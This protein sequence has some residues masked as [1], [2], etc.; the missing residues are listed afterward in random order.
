VPPRSTRLGGNAAWERLLACVAVMFVIA[1]DGHP[2]SAEHVPAAPRFWGAD[3]LARSAKRAPFPAHVSR[4]STSRS[5]RR[6]LLALRGGRPDALTVSEF[7]MPDQDGVLIVPGPPDSALRDP[8]VPSAPAVSHADYVRARPGDIALTPGPRRRRQAFPGGGQLRR[9]R[10][11]RA[12]PR[13]LAPLGRVDHVGGPA[14][15]GRP[16]R[17]RHRGQTSCL[18]RAPASARLGAPGRLRRAEPPARAR[19]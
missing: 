12:G 11:M 15:P 17:A 3:S 7:R 4:E 5:V 9:G 1:A 8:P 19:S 13:R 14:E 2:P 18:A 6:G 16:H 10:G